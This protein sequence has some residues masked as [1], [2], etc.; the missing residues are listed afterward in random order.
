[1]TITQ[2]AIKALA[3]KA[4]I[5]LEHAEH[6]LRSEQT[7]GRPQTNPWP[8]G[9][10]VNKTQMEL[11][12]D[13]LEGQGVPRAEAT[14][15]VIKTGDLSIIRAQIDGERAR[16]QAVLDEKAK[17]D[18]LTYDENG[19]AYQAMEHRKAKE[20]RAARLALADEVAEMR[21]IP[22]PEL[23]TEEERLSLLDPPDPAMADTVE[24]NLRVLAEIDAV[25]EGEGQ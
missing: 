15:T 10:K 2:E 16:Q 25:R 3:E 12:I 19:I 1:M 17:Q 23:L 7:G 22:S 8:V 6:V 13:L 21:G 5:S 24:N 11:A 9:P 4:G 18:W 20:E 14:D